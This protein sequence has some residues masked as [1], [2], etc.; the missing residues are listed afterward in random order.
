M[1]TRCNY[2]KV[3]N[4]TAFSAYDCA[5]FEDL[6]KCVTMVA[7]GTLKAVECLNNM[8][9]SVAINWSGGWHHAHR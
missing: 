3:L 4:F 5:P 7:G 9:H 2:L 1:W 8:S 6:Y